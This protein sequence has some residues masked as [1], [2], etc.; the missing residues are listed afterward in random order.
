MD[1]H[2]Q[3]NTWPEQEAVD[4]WVQKNELEGFTHEELYDLKRSV[5]AYRIDIQR[6]LRGAREEIERLRKQAVEACS[7]RD[8][9][10]C[11]GHAMAK[12]SDEF[13][14]EIGRLKEY[15]A[16]D[17][18]LV[19]LNIQTMKEQGERIAEL[20]GAI[21]EA[22]CEWMNLHNAGREGGARWKSDERG[23]CVNAAGVNQCLAY[24]W[25]HRALSTKETDHL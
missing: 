13:A 24:C 8:Q 12:R 22:P 14:E 3:G 5:S 20:E 10:I 25:K 9:A 17:D 4:E 2:G 11:V 21:R 15:I 18:I 7:E 19:K 16:G 23:L 6:E 1:K